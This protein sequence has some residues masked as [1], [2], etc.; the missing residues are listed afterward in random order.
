MAETEEAN[1]GR[2]KWL[3]KMNS[4][5]GQNNIGVLGRYPQ[6]SHSLSY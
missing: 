3:K 1:G 2:I 5:G 6:Q 4:R